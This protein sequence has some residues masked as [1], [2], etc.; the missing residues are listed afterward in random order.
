VAPVNAFKSVLT[1]INKMLKANTKEE[2]TDK[3]K[4]CEVR[5]RT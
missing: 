4:N 1:E 2:Q 3:Q 5:R